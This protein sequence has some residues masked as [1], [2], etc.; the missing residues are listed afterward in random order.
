MGFLVDYRTIVTAAHVVNRSLGR[1]EVETSY[2][3]RTRVYVEFV[4]LA[5]G[6]VARRGEVVAWAYSDPT[7]YLGDDVA[8]ISLEEIAPNGAV[9]MPLTLNPTDSEV[10]LFGPFPDQNKGGWVSARLMETVAGGHLQLDQQGAPDGIRVQPE[11]SGG[12]VWH[13]KSGT[14][15]GMLLSHPIDEKRRDLYAISGERICECCPEQLSYVVLGSEST[16]PRSTVEAKP[17]AE[18]LTQQDPTE[19][20]IRSLEERFGQVAEAVTRIAANLDRLERLTVLPNYEIPRR[21]ELLTLADVVSEVET[22]R[23]LVKLDLDF[24][25]ELRSPGSQHKFLRAAKT[26]REL[27]EKGATVLALAGQGF[28]AV[29]PL[30]SPSV[31]S[32]SLH[33][34]VLSESLGGAASVVP[35]DLSTDLGPQLK[36]LNSRTIGLLPNLADI[37]PEDVLISL[38]IDQGNTVEL[39]QIEEV[40]VNSRLVGLLKP[41]YDVFVLD[42]FRS[43]VHRLPSNVGLAHEKP[44]CIGR[45]MEEDLDGLERLLATCMRLGKRTSSRRVVVSGSSRPDDIGVVE[46]LLQTRL[47]D[48]CLLGTYGSLMVMA[49]QGKSLSTSLLGE[50]AEL[51]AVNGRRLEALLRAPLPGWPP[52]TLIV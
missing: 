49:R 18:S 17:T 31:H 48:Q 4:M 10:L 7:G 5:D 41:H 47:F 20:R 51:A 39:P 9:P 15:Y 52:N 3:G 43:T 45:G 38:H 23:V 11:W 22:G 37:S 8:A 25:S 2:P 1:G 33:G 24:T 35:I 6:V 42:D 26:L 19:E 27:V 13:R 28:S 29:K 50:V 12:P 21:T 16:D 44:R 36:A 14:V 30:E 32:I 40:C 34:E 46:T